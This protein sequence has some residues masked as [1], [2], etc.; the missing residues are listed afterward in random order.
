M[1]LVELS[2]APS[3]DPTQVLLPEGW[4]GMPTF[5]LAPGDALVFEVK[6]R[7]DPEPEANQLSLQRTVWL[8]FDGRGYTARDQISGTVSR[9]WRLE[10]LASTRLGYLELNGQPQ[11]ITRLSQ[12]GP[13]GVEVRQGSLALTAESRMEKTAGGFPAL[14]WDHP[15]QSVRA[16]LNLPPGWEVF[17]VSGVDNIPDSWLQRWT[18]FDLFLVLV[19]SVAAA[20]LWGWRWGA[21]FLVTLALLWHEGGAPQ[22]T[23]INLISV[24]AL[25]RVVGDVRRLRRSLELYRALTALVLV[26]LLIPFSVDQIRTAIYPQLERP[27]QPIQGPVPRSVPEAPRPAE[28]KRALKE[29]LTAD[30]A[31]QASGAPSSL[32]ETAERSRAYDY[33]LGSFD[34]K[35]KLQTGPGLPQWRWNA[36]Q[37]SWNGPVQPEQ[38]VDI[39]YLSPPLNSVLNWLRVALALLLTWHLVREMLPGRRRTALSALAP[40]LLLPLLM[41]LQ[42]REAMADYPPAE[43]L[44]E[45]EQRLLEP[46]RCL[47]GCAGIP[48]ARLTV[49]ADDVLELRLDMHVTERIGAPLPGR[50]G[51]WEPNVVTVDGRVPPLARSADGT[52]Y[53]VLEAGV[54]SVVMRGSV[55]GANA[56]Q[57]H[58]PLVPKR[59]RVAAEGWDITGFREPDVPAQQMQLTRMK[60]EDDKAVVWEPVTVPPFVV[61]EKTFRIGLD[62]EI[63]QRVRRVTPPGQSIV[64]R[65]PLLPG[66]AVITEGVPIRD[67]FVEVTLGPDQSTF[68]WQS[69]LEKQSRLELEAADEDSWVEVWRFAVSP[70]WHVEYDGIPPV[71]HTDRA[72]RWLP[73]WH[74]WPGESLTASLERPEGILGPTVTIESSSLTVK[75]GRRASDAELTLAVRS[76]QGSK[77]RVRIPDGAELLSVTIDGK[78]QPIRQ[79]GGEVILP[80]RPGTQTIGLT[81]RSP[82]PVTTLTRTP[83]I[84]LGGLHVNAALQMNLGS[85]RWIL[86]TGGPAMGPA[87]LFWGVVIVIILVAFVLGRIHLT[88]LRTWQ[89]V[90]LGLGL[91]Q[92]PLLFGA[93]V[94]A[95]FFVLAYRGRATMPAGALR[96]NAI[97]VGLALMTLLVIGAIIAAV[98]QG[99]LGWPSMLVTGNGSTAYLLNWYQ[100]RWG[101]GYPQARV[102]SVPLI[103]YRLL[104]LVWALWLAF[105]SVSWL[106]WGW[107]QYASGGLYRSRTTQSGK[108]P[109]HEEAPE[110]LPPGAG[111]EKPE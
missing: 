18:L 75:P 100:D 71:H 50:A 63:D 49:S 102:I 13:A 48:R 41:V 22:W 58:F 39:L 82:G 34:P 52:L 21:A 78:A 23:W 47:P 104:M 10:T 83:G 11:L 35:A 2:G 24:T 101:A 5:R 62:W 19:T 36:I 14:G 68:Q 95:W 108:A 110:T 103:V 45:L 98:Q 55:S 74:P 81:W 42:P 88:P 16:Q 15:F 12:D 43:L 26:L 93:L 65:V 105:A 76:S 7:G 25:L 32:G 9:G 64:L 107:Q 30:S 90:L 69:R 20:R 92:V 4:G 85:D 59:L 109:G 70:V 67:G 37:L 111:G 89:W 33:G 72:S 56:V 79:E 51:H 91:S 27:E 28:P 8:D 86:W 99:L 96:Y 61:L 46:P 97:Q 80:L 77:R 44:N 94:V 6:R 54:H 38:R 53:V 40:V 31:R 57:L 17:S 73:S 84:D 87:V 60:P 3:I 29:E 66:E 1:R 106:R